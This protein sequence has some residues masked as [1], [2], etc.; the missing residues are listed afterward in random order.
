MDVNWSHLSIFPLQGLK[1]RE[2]RRLALNHPVVGGRE[3]FTTQIS[4]FQFRF[5]FLE[6]PFGL[7]Q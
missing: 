5:F 3:E 2:E 6:S 1:L 4:W 7:F